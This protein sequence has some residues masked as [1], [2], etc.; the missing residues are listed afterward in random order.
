VYVENDDKSV[1]RGEAK[2][3]QLND[4]RDVFIMKIVTEERQECAVCGS[5]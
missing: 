2:E 4:K 5:V 1:Q 3:S